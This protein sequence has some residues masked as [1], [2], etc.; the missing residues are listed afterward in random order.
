MQTTPQN[1]PIIA[2]AEG[3][4]KQATRLALFN[5]LLEVQQS[6][7]KKH[8]K[9]PSYLCIHPNDNSLLKYEMQTFGNTPYPISLIISF[10]VRKMHPFL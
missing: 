10:N 1:K 4:L 6:F 7:E 3:I 8:L 2:D 5:N 9:V